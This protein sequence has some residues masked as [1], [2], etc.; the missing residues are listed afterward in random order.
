[1]LFSYD[2]DAATPTPQAAPVATGILGTEVAAQL[3]RLFGST[4]TAPEIVDVLLAEATARKISDIL[5]EPIAD[6]TRVRMRLDGILLEAARIPATVYPALVARIKVLASLDTAAREPSQEGKFL[7]TEE[8]HVVNVRVAL[9]AVATG[10]MIALRLH[11]SASA[12]YALQEHGMDE[13]TRTAYEKLLTYKSGLILVCGPTGAGKTSTLY[14]S[15]QILNTGKTNIV[16]IE[17]PVEYVM[18]GINQMQVD[19]EHGLGFA[20]GLRV[21][22]RLNPDIILVGEVRDKATA[23]IGIEASLTGHLVLT[24]LHANSAISAISRLQDLQIEPFFINAAVKGIMC[25]RLVRKS[26]TKCAAWQAPSE[27]S[28]QLFTQIMGRPLTQESVGAGCEA[29]AGTG[30]QGRIGMYELITMNDAVRDI[31]THPRTEQEAFGLLH[32]QGFRSLVEDGLLKVEA[33]L[34]TVLEVVS[35]AYSDA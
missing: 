1:M 14:S 17:D 21:I 28:Q 20:S 34:T 23:Q 24:T 13:T 32:A 7:Y 22:L 31:V 30:F 6:Y 27:T 9:T 33:G 29:C 2:D 3:E 10:D 16:S 35:N 15:L 26:C 8:G 19:E 18:D 25:Q 5:F 11:D 4:Q 12:V